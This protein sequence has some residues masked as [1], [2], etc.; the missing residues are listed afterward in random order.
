L[1]FNFLHKIYT[2]LILVGVFFLVSCENNVEKVKLLT[3]NID[4]PLEESENVK[5]IY[6]DS[7]YSKMVIEAPKLERFNTEKPYTE[8]KDGIHVTF[9]N[10]L[11]EKESE[12][13]ADYAID[14]EKEN[15]ME[16]KGNV[17][18]INVNGDKLN[19]EHLIWLE[20]E[21]RIKSDEFVKI[22]TQ[23]E[24]IYGDGLDANEDFTQYRI[25][26]IKGVITIKEEKENA[27]VQ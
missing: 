6:S 2:P 5:I 25:K 27:E 19:T 16:A 13:F 3:E 7:G 1:K 9:F 20:S 22:Q 4:L 18:V 17:V 11:G 12:L 21:K 26:N 15:L 14:Y 10:K 8:F 24:I 23:E